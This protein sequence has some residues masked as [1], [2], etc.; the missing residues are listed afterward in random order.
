MTLS[1]LAPA[2]DA[3]AAA[4]RIVAFTGAGVSAESGIPTYRGA[5]GLWRD[6]RAEDLA[7]MDA[8]KRD[9]ALVWEWYNERRQR[10]RECEPNAA[11]RA[12]AALQASIGQRLTLITQNIDDLH[13][14]AGSR[15]PVELHGNAFRTVCLGCDFAVVDD[16]AEPRQVIRCPTCGSLLRPA[17]VWFG[18]PLDPGVLDRA[19]GA[20]QGCDALICIGSS[21]QVQP[22]AALPFEALRRGAVVVE[23]NT[24]PT[25][26]TDTIRWGFQGSAGDIVPRLLAGATAAHGGGD[27]A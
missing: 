14:R 6:L 27:R 11:H 24:E 15:D 2:A 9:P 18:E 10:M 22:A 1:E 7:T 16:E 26:L 5:G 8:F 12:L 23:V 13:R 20:A 21:L 3:I 25:P 17:V 4:D 19:Y